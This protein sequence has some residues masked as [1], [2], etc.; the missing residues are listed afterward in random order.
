MNIAPIQKGIG[1]SATRVAESIRDAANWAGRQI[2]NGFQKFAELMKSAWNTV[3][4]FLKEVAVQTTSFLRTG[5]GVALMAGVAGSFLAY[6]SVQMK[7]QK[8]IALAL[9]VS[10]YAAFIGAGVALGLGLSKGL[11]APL[12]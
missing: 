8:W 12:F 10:A 5:P 4:P 2:V 3:Y 7:D 11:S 9:Q 6:S 1:S